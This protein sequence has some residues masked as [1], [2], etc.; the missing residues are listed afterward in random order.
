MLHCINR[1]LGHQ[2]WSQ[3]LWWVFLWQTQIIKTWVV[4]LAKTHLSF[5]PNLNFKWGAYNQDLARV[6]LKK[7]NKQAPMYAFP[8]EVLSSALPFAQQCQ[9]SYPLCSWYQC[10]PWPLCPCYPPPRIDSSEI[11]KSFWER[12]KGQCKHPPL[13]SKHGICSWTPP[14]VDEFARILLF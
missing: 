11:W 9:L 8:S 10:S 6:D 5:T 12:S 4:Q 13:C 14:T 2:Q 1:W 7:C 3:V